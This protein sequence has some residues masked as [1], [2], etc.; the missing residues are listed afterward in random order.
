MYYE[1]D[2]RENKTGKVTRARIFAWWSGE[3]SIAERQRMCDCQLGAFFNMKPEDFNTWENYMR[4]GPGGVQLANRQLEYLK[5]HDCNHKPSRKYTVTAAY[6][7][8]GE[9]IEL[10]EKAAA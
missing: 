10:V 8:S 6:L 3:H 7:P 1:F 5:H 9:T 2:I 4:S